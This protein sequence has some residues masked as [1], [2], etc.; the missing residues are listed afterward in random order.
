MNM[1]SQRAATKASSSHSSQETPLSTGETIVPRSSLLFPPP[2]AAGGLN[3]TAS[4]E[5]R[6][7][8]PTKPEELGRQSP[9]VPGHRLKYRTPSKKPH[10]HFHRH[11]REAG[12]TAPWEGEDL[13]REGAVA[14]FTGA[15]RAAKSIQKTPKTPSG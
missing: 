14:L 1:E 11:H 8:G 13:N 3:P 6:A 4:R 15:N 5:R 10:T 9:G 7:K 2:G 12:V